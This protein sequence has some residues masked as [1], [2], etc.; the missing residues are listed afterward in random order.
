MEKPAVV[1]YSHWIQFNAMSST[2]KEKAKKPGSRK[3]S[4]K[5]KVS[6][7]KRPDALQLDVWQF[8][9]RKQ[10]GEE[11]R[12]VISN[13][14]E[15]P[16]FST[17]RV[18]NPETKNDYEVWIRNGETRFGHIPG[19]SLF[20]TGNLCTCHDFRTNRLGMCKHISAVLSHLGKKRG[21]KKIL[22][23]SFRP[24]DTA[25]YLD[26]LSGREVRIAIGT[27]KTEEFEE[28]SEA[29]FDEEGRIRPDTFSGFNKIILEGRKIHPGFFCTPD[30]FEFILQ[31]R[32]EIGRRKKIRAEIPGGAEDPFFDGLMANIKLYPYQRQGILFGANAGRCLIADEMGLGKTIQAIGTAELLKRVTGIQKVIIIC[33][34][35]LKYQWKSEIR[36]F[37]GQEA[38]VVEGMQ[39][40]RIKIYEES[41]SFYHIMSYNV[42]TNDVEAINRMD[43][44]LIIL[45][46]A[47]RIKNF[48]TK[49]ATQLKKIYTPYC[50]V[51]TGTP[52]ENK[53]EELYSIVQFVD[54]FKLPPLYRFLDRYQ[55]ME[56][57]RVIGYRNLKEIS[58]ILGSCMIRRL[59]K[60]VIKQLPKRVDKHLFVPMTSQQATIHKELE[61]NVARL[62]AK[63]KRYNFLNETDRRRLI[64]S[65]SQMRM[66]CDSTFILDQ[67]TR[68]DTKIDELM[69]ILEEALGDPDQKV[70]IFSQWERMT[71]LVAQQL[72]AIEVGFAWLHGGV[73]SRSRGDLLEKFREDA[74]C[75]I[76]LSTD[77]GGVGLNLQNASLVINL[78]LPWNPAVLEQR[79]ARVFRIGQKSKVTVINMV[80]TNTIEHRMLSVLAFKAEMAK[81][82]LDPEGEDAIFMSASRFKKLMENIEQ[83]STSSETET[84]LFGEPDIGNEEE[85]LESPDQAKP[86]EAGAGAEHAGV[87]T[88]IGDD[89]IK[90]SGKQTE[91]RE[92]SGKEPP[93][94]EKAGPEQI[95]EVV[96]SGISFFSGLANILN[97][98]EKTAELVE[99]L[100]QKDESSGETY[101]KIP[102][103]NKEVVSN[104]LEAFRKL[105]S[106]LGN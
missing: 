82:V 91:E 25:I 22:K 55:V 28:W 9:L 60:E 16:V 34:T 37:T 105:V 1:L 41:E 68:F 97:N 50:L 72:E 31:K 64:L 6:Y 30:A 35:S 12:F 78:D 46:E 24:P 15:E 42:G 73:E 90:E 53:L 89:D 54:Q 4:K 26:Y 51:L 11:S 75:R 39:T 14:G 58:E 94:G 81:G 100:V 8:A 48:R 61:D 29:Y 85:N 86:G 21:N 70:V 93:S 23:Q 103:E 47:Q 57:G 18:F 84:N 95:G 44:D 33:P 99:S 74:D 71:R 7:H 56:E 17:F 49:A 40:K 66:V 59:K 3:K 36:K 13:I 62:V 102:I 32:E 83:L 67:E 77:A 45:D 106:A 38:V 27:E 2:A 76:F 43:A 63:W 96:Q 52:L 69:Y 104:A 20:Q 19:P 87:D 98:R 80:A 65:L 101:L 79:I 88:F 5:Q 92:K 10:F